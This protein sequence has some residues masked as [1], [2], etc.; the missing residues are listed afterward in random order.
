MHSF[1][2]PNKIPTPTWCSVMCDA[3]RHSTLYRAAEHINTVLLLLFSVSDVYHNAVHFELLRHSDGQ[4]NL[5]VAV[6]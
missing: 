2:N 4:D 1:T 5:P 3:A 6:E